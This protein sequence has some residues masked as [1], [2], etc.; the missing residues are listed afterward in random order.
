M[1]KEKSPID[2]ANEA[3]K[4]TGFTQ[5]TTKGPLFAPVPKQPKSP[6]YIKEMNRQRVLRKKNRKE[7]KKGRKSSR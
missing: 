6:E 2:Q 5:P 4:H 1:N 3:A 7:S